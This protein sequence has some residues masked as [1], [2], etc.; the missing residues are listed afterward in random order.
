MALSEEQAIQ[1]FR[2]M[3]E[4]REAERP[5]L[6]NI[7][8]YLRDEQK[9]G[10]IPNSAPT[11]VKDLGQIS[12]VNMMKFVVDAATQ[13]LFVDGFR[14]PRTAEDD[15][16]W[17][18]WQRNRMD[19]K[20]IG[21]HRG[22]TSYGASYELVLPGDPVPVI[23]GLSPR[24][25]T[26]VYEDDDDW[27]EYALEVRKDGSYRMYDRTTVYNFKT[28]GEKEEEVELLNS[29]SHGA[30]VCPVVRVRD[31]D[32][33]D[34]EVVG[35]VEPLINLQDQINMTTFGL[36]V[37]QHYGA[38]RQRYILGWMANSEEQKL[39]ASA[40]KLWTFED[41]PQDIQ[42]GEFDQT[43][44]SGYINSRESTV[45]YLSAISQ[46]PAHELL[47]Q[48]VN[49]SAEALAAAND[50]HRAKITEIQTVA[51]EAHEQTLSLAGT[52]AGYTVDPSAYVRWKDTEPRSM[53]QMADALGKL[54]QQ[55]GVPQE[56]LWEMIPDVSQQQV[57][58]WR[59]AAAEQPEPDE[60]RAS[61]SSSAASAE[62]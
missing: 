37:A 1:Q 31:T 49:L 50:S 3:Q 62:A 10:F 4:I 53:A 28:S 56:E 36:M 18:I 11:E 29:F 5:R 25:M 13:K 51:G 2:D 8:A 47:G 46:T 23:R 42:V 58:R 40:A 17:N 59:K 55:L 44:P 7:Y 35:Q 30:G 43:D 52:L 22:A 54:A 39:R 60:Q 9:L 19:A 20:Q 34:D 14:A 61:E 12:R 21:I 48:L 16:V 32:N 27:P 41:S 24:Y 6:D 57:E 38:F 33:L 15:P 26:V 45:R